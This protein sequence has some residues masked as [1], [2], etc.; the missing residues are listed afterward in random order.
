MS[1]STTASSSRRRLLVVATCGLLACSGGD[2]S[3]AGTDTRAGRDAGRDAGTDAGNDAAV[4]VA[5][6]VG[7]DATDDVGRDA[8]R[9]VGADADAGPDPEWQRLPGFP[10][11]C[12]VARARH[13]E[14]VLAFHWEPCTDGIVGCEMIVF[15]R[16]IDPDLR[17]Y[18]LAGGNSAARI[19]AV[20]SRDS[21]TPYLTISVVRDDAVV[22]AWRGGPNAHGSGCSTELAASDDG[23]GVDTWFMAAGGDGFDRISTAPWRDL[24]SLDTDTWTSTPASIPTNTFLEMPSASA[25][26]YAAVDTNGWVIAV[27]SDREATID[28][29]GD[30][31]VVIGR[32]VLWDWS[33]TTTDTAIHVGGLDVLETTL[34]TPPSGEHVLAV[35]SDG[36]YIAFLQGADDP[37]GATYPLNE[38]WVAPFRTTAPLDAHLVRDDIMRNDIDAAIGDGM[39]AYVTGVA[40]A[41]QVCVVDLASAERRCVDLPFDLTPGGVRWRAPGH[42]AWV[43]RSEVAFPASREEGSTPVPTLLRVALSTLAPEPAPMDAGVDAGP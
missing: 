41:E 17:P 5:R 34:Y 10:D 7:T 32:A 1:R 38:L 25:T 43:T 39:Y 16:A 18:G 22:A 24:A 14:N 4:D 37:T 40:T 21:A 35:R 19:W 13:P 3:D 31:P 12:Y 42:V 6:D 29:I 20:G 28:T 33:V 2:A 9:D 36:T 15:D 23:L 26:T 30:G 27:E 11:D 8:A